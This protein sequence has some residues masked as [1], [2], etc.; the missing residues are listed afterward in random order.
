MATKS[1]NPREK[2][3]KAIMT[4]IAMFAMQETFTDDGDAQQYLA[5]AIEKLDLAAA[6]L[7]KN[8]DAERKEIANIL[9]S[10]AEKG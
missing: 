4:K 5:N 3:L 2:K 1:I 8:D 6:I 9:N 7:V 10:G